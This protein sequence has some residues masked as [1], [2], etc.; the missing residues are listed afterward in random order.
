V[1]C[2]TGILIGSYGMASGRN[3]FAGMR[4]MGGT[5][6]GNLCPRPDRA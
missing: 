6:D 5:G 2:R 3:G 4:G 1:A